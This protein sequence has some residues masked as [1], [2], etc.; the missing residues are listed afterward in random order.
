MQTKVQSP[1]HSAVNAGLRA[2]RANLA[3]GLVLQAAALGIVLAY[4]LWPP[5]TEALHRLT[6]F[7]GRVGMPFAM[8]STALCGGLIPWLCISLLQGPE[9]RIGP[10]RGLL[11]CLFWAYKGIEVGLFY[12]LLAGFVGEGNSATVIISKV[13]ID[14]FVYAPLIAIPGTVLF[15]SWVEY[16][17][18]LRPFL[19]DLAAPGWYLRRVLTP[20]VAN[21]GIWLPATV[22]IYSLPTALQ[23]PMQNIVLVF[24]TLI[25]SRVAR[26]AKPASEAQ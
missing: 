12:S 15:Y 14:Q 18:S 4:F 25:L 19:R 24:F 26:H 23:L 8:V 17:Y 20:L 22:I 9:H 6:E 21:L 1:L 11:T 2:M 7:R 16:G 3:P 10:G 5:A 13:L